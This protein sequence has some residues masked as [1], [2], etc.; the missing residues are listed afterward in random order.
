[1]IDEAELLFSSGDV[2]SALESVQRTHVLDNKI[3]RLKLESFAGL[4]SQSMTMIQLLTRVSQSRWRM[5]SHDK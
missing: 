2:D 4:P 1:M 3:N 5:R